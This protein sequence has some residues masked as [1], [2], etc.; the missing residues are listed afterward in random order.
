MISDSI[1]N[2]VCVLSGK[3]PKSNR[4]PAKKAKT[5]TKPAKKPVSKPKWNVS[6]RKQR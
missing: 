5:T 4:K 2:S 3:L 1:E 6:P